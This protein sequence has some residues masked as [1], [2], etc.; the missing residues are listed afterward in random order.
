MNNFIFEMIIITNEFMSFIKDDIEQ[1][2]CAY[3]CG[4]S[5]KIKLE[6]L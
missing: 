3:T 5:F 6:F 2:Y 1:L 4:C